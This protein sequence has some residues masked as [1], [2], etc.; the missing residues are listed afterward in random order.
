VV[1]RGKE[2]LYIPVRGRADVRY[3]AERLYTYDGVPDLTVNFG[4]CESGN[5]VLEKVYFIL[6]WDVLTYLS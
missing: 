6:M 1:G 3:W 5:G 2:V 4:I